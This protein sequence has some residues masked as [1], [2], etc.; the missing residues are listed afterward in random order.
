MRALL[1]AVAVL[2]IGVS[3]VGA[4]QVPPATG[5]V[6]ATPIPIRMLTADQARADISVMSRALEA[7]HPGL[8]RRAPRRDI[9][10]AFAELTASVGGGVSDVELYR[11]VSVVL[12]MIRCTHTKADQTEAMQAW[13]TENP[14]HLPFRFRIIDGRMLVVSSDAAQPAIA[15]GA[16]ILSI[17][18]RPVAQLIRTL[19]AYVPI[20]G[21]TEAPRAAYLA[22][23]GDL[24]GADFDHFYPY[25]FGFPSKW[26]IVFRESDRAPRRTLT[27]APITFRAWV[28]LETEGRPF[29]QNFGD[30]VSWRMLSADV[31]YLRVD[32]FVNYRKPTD[33]AALYTRALDD[34]RASGAQKLII[35]LRQNGGGSND[36]SL[37]LIDAVATAPYTYQR[38]MRYRALR[39]GDLPQYISTWGDRDALFNPPLGRF[40]QTSDG[41]FELRPEYSPD[42]LM[43][44]LPAPTP[45]IGPV[46]VLIGP[47]NA[48]GA[49]MVIAKL[50]DMG[51]VR[52][53]GERS[54]GSADGP[55]A[56][57]IFN[58][59]LP[60]SGISVR[61]PLVFN[62]M[63]VERFDPKGGVTP[64]AY[65]AEAVEDFRAKRDRTLE[66]AVADL[67]GEST[68]P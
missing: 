30:A 51:R 37:A 1:L 34:L 29:R 52:L 67:E 64:D 53:V 45:F 23:D 63:A 68:P 28:R 59:K 46:T 62:Q 42:E 57:T 56:G 48:S 21:D 39:Y 32:T 22:D 14:S 10:R 8:F 4:A 40:T 26:K 35:D 66:R 49:T 6:P 38:A 41:W 36:A 19:G 15:R 20:D 27:L 47:A 7:I 60:N 55:T 18:G 5:S 54:G 2:G 11:R 44:R 12:A 50:R 61:V 25:V 16:E 33:A 17:N 65:V 9:D 24:M 58:V 31:G 13:R 3:G 43:P